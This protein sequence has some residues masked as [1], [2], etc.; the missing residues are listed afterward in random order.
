[1]EWTT[2]LDDF[3]INLKHSSYQIKGEEASITVSHN[4]DTLRL[5]GQHYV[6][7]HILGVFHGRFYALDNIIFAIVE[8]PALVGIGNEQIVSE[9]LCLSNIR[10]LGAVVQGVV[11]N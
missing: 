9:L 8:P 10:Q 1:M 11:D 7:P 3:K 2:D 6:L 4:G 5:G